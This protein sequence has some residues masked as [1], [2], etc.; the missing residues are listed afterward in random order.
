MRGCNAP[1]THLSFTFFLLSMRIRL[2]PISSI[3]QMININDMKMKTCFCLWTLSLRGS[4]LTNAQEIGANFNHNPEII[5]FVYLKKTPVEWVRT[6]P[7][8]FEYIFGNQSPSTDIGFG[9][10]VDTKKHGFKGH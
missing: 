9:Q 1:L 8:I 10:F 2:K 7:Y 4:F 5:D 6:T 3:Y